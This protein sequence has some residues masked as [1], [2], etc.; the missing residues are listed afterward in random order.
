MVW[1]TQAVLPALHQN[2]VLLWQEN[3]KFWD[4]AV[5]LNLG[6]GGRHGGALG[7]ARVWEGRVVG[8][9][10]EAQTDEVCVLVFTCCSFSMVPAR[11]IEGCQNKVIFTSQTTYY[12]CAPLSLHDKHAILALARR[13]TTR[14]TQ[15]QHI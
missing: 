3:Y 8:A 14:F 15:A 6:A 10:W 13:A 9:G 1:V 5:D 4:R 11:E 12:D 7:L 2:L